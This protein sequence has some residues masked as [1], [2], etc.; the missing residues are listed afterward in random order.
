M[1]VYVLVYEWA[2]EYDRQNEVAGVYSTMRKAKKEL[3][4]IA[5]DVRQNDGKYYDNCYV[6]D[7][8]QWGAEKFGEYDEA[9]TNLFIQEKELE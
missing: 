8:L 4:R 2:N 3:K 7:G 9:H 5:R 1:K 6:D